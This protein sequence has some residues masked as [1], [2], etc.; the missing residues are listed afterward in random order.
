[1]RP[2]NINM[3]YKNAYILLAYIE[4]WEYWIKWLSE[5]LTAR[6]S[7]LMI[8]GKTQQNNTK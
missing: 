6:G 3:H 7:V 1:M 4:L 2:N 5:S 8:R